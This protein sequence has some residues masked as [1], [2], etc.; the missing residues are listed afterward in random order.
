[1]NASERE[2]ACMSV[3]AYATRRHLSQK[4]VDIKEEGK[5]RK[6]IN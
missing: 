5:P 3:C 2:K 1:M 4:T 6:T